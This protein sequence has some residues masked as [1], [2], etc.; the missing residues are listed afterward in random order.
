MALDVRKALG[1]GLVS[2]QWLAGHANA[3]APYGAAPL[4]LQVRN[5]DI[6]GTLYAAGLS[7]AGRPPQIPSDPL[8]RLVGGGWLLYAVGGKHVRSVAE[9]DDALR[10]AVLTA[11]TTEPSAAARGA[12]GAGGDLLHLRLVLCTVHADPAYGAIAMSQ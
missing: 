10:D 2:V 6:S 3:T 8:Q 1:L 7:A 11:P 9:A 12:A 5:V 4:A